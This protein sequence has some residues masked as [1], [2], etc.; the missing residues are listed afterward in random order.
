ML[1]AFSLAKCREDKNVKLRFVDGYFDESYF[2]QFREQADLLGVGYQVIFSGYVN[3]EEYERLLRQ[4]D[5]VIQLRALTRGETSRAVLDLM[6]QGKPVILNRFATF[7][8]YPEEVVFFI[9]DIPS[10]EELSRA[11]DDMYL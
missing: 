11:V 8:D 5:V 10:A 2:K 7:K 9:L 4:T 1:E 6:A 3:D